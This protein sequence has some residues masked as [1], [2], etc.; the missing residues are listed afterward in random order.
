MADE[1][2]LKAIKDLNGTVLEGRSIKVMEAKPREEKR[3]YVS[4]RW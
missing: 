1:D 4:S 3:S 2:A